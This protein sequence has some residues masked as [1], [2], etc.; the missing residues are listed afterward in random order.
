MNASDLLQTAGL[1][2]GRITVVFVG[3]RVSLQPEQRF[4]PCTATFARRPPVSKSAIVTGPDGLAFVADVPGLFIADR[5]SGGFSDSHR[6]VAMP[7][8]VLEH[9][10]RPGHPH[11]GKVSLQHLTGAVNDARCTEATIAASLE[12]L[13]VEANPKPD[14]TFVGLLGGTSSPAWV[15]FCE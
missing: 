9:R 8:S 2:N 1:R 5:S 6:F 13:T 12:R 15:E 14:P 3:D 4:A 11:S 7:R 10:S